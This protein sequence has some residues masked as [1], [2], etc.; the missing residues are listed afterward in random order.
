LF[1]VLILWL[2]T[3]T[4]CW[5]SFERHYL[6]DTIHKLFHNLK[7]HFV[8]KLFLKG[9]EL[10]DSVNKIMSLERR[11]TTCPG[12]QPQYQRHEQDQGRLRLFG[13]PE[14]IIKYTS[15]K[16][17]YN[18]FKTKL[19]IFKLHNNIKNNNPSLQ[20]PKY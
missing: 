4:C 3:R 1:V 9:W 18:F 17:K 5:S 20:L 2:V 19:H 8:D 10:M 13:G 12:C 14:L 16:K 11:S 6:V 15:N 7:R